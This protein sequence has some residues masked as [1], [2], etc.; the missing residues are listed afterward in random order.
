MYQCSKPPFQCAVELS[1][2]VGVGAEEVAPS[3]RLLSPPRF[4]EG[5]VPSVD[6]LTRKENFVANLVRS[7]IN[8]GASSSQACLL[9]HAQKARK[10]EGAVPVNGGG[11]K[12][13]HAKRRSKIG[14]RRPLVGTPDDESQL[15]RVADAA[16]GSKVAAAPGVTTGQ[17]QY[18]APEPL[19]ISVTPQ[20]VLRKRYDCEFLDV[21]EKEQA[22]EGARAEA[23]TSA[24]A[25]V[26]V[27]Q[28]RVRIMHNSD[29]ALH[30]GATPSSA[31]N[32][33]IETP[34]R[35]NNV[36]EG[37]G[38]DIRDEGLIKGGKW[39]PVVGDSGSVTDSERRKI[40]EMA[41]TTQELKRL[42]EEL[43]SERQLASERIMRMSE[44]YE[45]DIRKLAEQYQ[46]QHHHHLSGCF[47]L[48]S[49]VYAQ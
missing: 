11:A 49:S 8:I 24:K 31:D 16:D 18:V 37:A 25:R 34:E 23:L 21:L 2:P 35:C 5:D 13:R 12:K 6:A 22:A 20:D 41:G 36:L 7:Y 1:R 46:D 40:E 32:D 26:K 28:D 47:A 27:Y 19:P 9:C 30:S 39:E 4:S 14:H 45:Y 33:G 48:P 15:H 43:A 38:N 42:T 29:R 3:T 10:K 17:E 44:A